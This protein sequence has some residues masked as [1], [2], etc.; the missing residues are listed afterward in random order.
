[1]K[2]GDLIKLNFLYNGKRLIGLVLD[3]NTIYWPNECVEII[4][5]LKQVASSS[6]ILEK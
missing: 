6:Q 1:M 3:D 4:N 2:I 5:S